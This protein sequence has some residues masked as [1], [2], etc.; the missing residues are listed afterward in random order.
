MYGRF[1]LC[2]LFLKCECKW[3]PAQT[4]RWRSETMSTG[5]CL[6]LSSRKESMP[7]VAA[8]DDDVGEAGGQRNDP[9][10]GLERWTRRSEDGAQPDRHV[11][12][13]FISRRR[14]HPHASH[15]QAG[16]LPHTYPAFRVSIHSEPSCLPLT[17]VPQMARTKYA[18]IQK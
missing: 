11:G 2:I 10:R 15:H 3:R 1:V 4:R 13:R 18:W 7:Y 5:S 16:L 9:H 14:H 17:S 6:P 12:I 8:D